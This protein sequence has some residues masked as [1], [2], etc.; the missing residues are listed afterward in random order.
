M[1]RFTID[2]VPRSKKNSQKIVV[3]KKTGRPFIMYSDAYKAYRKAALML[4]P[5]EA[6]QH[7][8]YPV[9][10]RALFYMET[11]RKV[12]LNN[13]SEALCDVLTDAGVIEDDNS[14]IV[15]GMDGSR[16]LYDKGHPRTEV[17][18]IPMEEW[19]DLV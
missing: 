6:R 15:A 18:I 4:I 13:L 8:D 12:D 16:V 14:G 7:I 5:P 10:V 17:E 9:N 2:A 3:N 11:R 1:I 19:G